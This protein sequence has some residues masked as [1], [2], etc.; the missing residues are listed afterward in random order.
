MDIG[1]IVIISPE[2]LLEMQILELHLRPTEAETLG[3]GYRY[4]SF[5]QV[6]QVILMH[7]KV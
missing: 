6:F 5:K 7:A 1:Q 4:L 2:R 3:V